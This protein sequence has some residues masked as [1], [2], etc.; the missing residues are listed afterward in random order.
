M[1]W[2]PTYLGRDFIPRKIPPKQTTRAFF[3]LLNW[4]RAEVSDIRMAQAN[5]LIWR[6]MHLKLSLQLVDARPVTTG[7]KEPQFRPIYGLS[8]VY[9][10][11]IFVPRAYGPISKEG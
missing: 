1:N 2:S 9:K 6:D 10:T 11:P 8:Y 3:S 5:P 7:V 4:K